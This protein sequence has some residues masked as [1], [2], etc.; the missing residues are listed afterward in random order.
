MWDSTPHSCQ[1]TCVYIP[2]N[3]E[4]SGDRATDEGS[5]QRRCLNGDNGRTA[6]DAAGSDAD[7]GSGCF[8]ES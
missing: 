1:S 3:D 7:A 2:D 4:L 6:A 8:L 5:G